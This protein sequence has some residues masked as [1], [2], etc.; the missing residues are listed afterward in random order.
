M[1]SSRIVAPSF[2]TH[3]FIF[4]GIP[5]FLRI[6]NR[7]RFVKGPFHLGKFSIPVA[8]IACAWIVL[9]AILFVLPQVNPVTSATFNYSI[10][11]VGIVI[12]YSIGLWLLSA[13]K[14]FHG[15]RRQIGPEES[16]G[17][18]ITEPGALSKVQADLGDLKGSDDEKRL[19]NL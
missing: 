14:W 17:V 13:R 6:L 11:A 3:V 19:P 7:E 5:V 18:D 10:V 9:I 16:A 8:V 12:T 2:L 15:P 1:V 4:P